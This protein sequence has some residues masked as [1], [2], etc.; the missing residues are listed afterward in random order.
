MDGNACG[1][2]WLPQQLGR[3]E[4]AWVTVDS[5]SM[6]YETLTAGASVGL[7]ELPVRQPRG[8]L[9]RSLDRLCLDA[10]VTRFSAWTENPILHPPRH[11]FAEADRCADEI[12]RRYFSAE[13]ARAA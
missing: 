7:L 13:L 11:T 8:K 1:A 2:D 6:V 10:D 12:V 3:C 9:A 4:Q 5:V